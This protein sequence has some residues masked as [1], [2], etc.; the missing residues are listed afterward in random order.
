MNG[1]G[2]AYRGRGGGT[3][4][5]PRSGRAGEGVSG[6]TTCGTRVAR[7]P[8]ARERRLDAVAAGEVAGADRDE[9]GAGPRHPLLDPAR[10][11]GVAVGEQQRVQRPVARAVVLLLVRSAPPAARRRRPTRRRASAPSLAAISSFSSSVSLSWASCSASGIA[12]SRRNLQL[13]PFELADRHV[14]GMGGVGEHR[15][16]P[17]AP[18]M[19]SRCAPSTASVIDTNQGSNRSNAVGGTPRRGQRAARAP[20]S[21]AGVSREESV[22]PLRIDRIAHDHRL[23]RGRI[24]GQDRLHHQ[25]VRRVE[26]GPDLVVEPGPAVEQVEGAEQIDGR[27]GVAHHPERRIGVGQRRG[28]AAAGGA[29]G[30]RRRRGRKPGAGAKASAAASSS[31]V[32]FTRKF[33]I[34]DS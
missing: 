15:L 14:P 20:H 25:L 13:E 32:I 34:V 22:R 7:M 17:A 23:Q 2:A 21:A 10:P 30:G 24:L 16:G 11:I 18:L 12:S 29:A 33:S 3:Q 31:L 8:C 28:G 5:A 19:P 4:A 1:E 26:R 9:H 27:V 6:A